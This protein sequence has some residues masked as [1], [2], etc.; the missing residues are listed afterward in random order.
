MSLPP[1]TRV[2]ARAGDPG[3]HTRLPRYVRGH[4]GEIVECTGEWPLP[5]D[6]ARGLVPPRVEPV[7]T[8]RFPAAQLWGEGDHVVTVEAWESYL[9]EAG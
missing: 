4:T 9:E 3:H 7:Y 5:D 1:G 6:G 2:R 8:V